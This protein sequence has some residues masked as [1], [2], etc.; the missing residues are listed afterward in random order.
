MYICHGRVQ[1]NIVLATENKTI[2]GVL[3]LMNQSFPAICSHFA[4]IFRSVP[5]NGGVQGCRSK[6]HEWVVR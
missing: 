1:S 6:G 3:C 4:V 5:E 2:P